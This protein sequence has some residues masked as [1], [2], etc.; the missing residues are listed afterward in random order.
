MWDPSLP[1]SP[2]VPTP[3]QSL[4]VPAVVPVVVAADFIAAAVRVPAPVP[5]APALV[6][7]AEDNYAD[8]LEKEWFDIG[9]TPVEVKDVPE[10]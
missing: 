5:V 7:V 4:K 2:T 9:K 1:A 10:F 8:F 6:R 3:C